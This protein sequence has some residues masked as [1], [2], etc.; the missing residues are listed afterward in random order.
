M[1]NLITIN[2][3]KLGV[4]GL[5]T[6]LL[7]IFIFLNTQTIEVN[8]IIAKIEIRRSIMIISAFAIGV[9]TGWAMKSFLTF[10]SKD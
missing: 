9:F 5:L 10:G 2:K 8:L 1:K 6:L 4:A 3:I 7:A